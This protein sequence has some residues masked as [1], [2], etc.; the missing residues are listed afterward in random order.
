[1]QNRK[2]VL[3]AHS[4]AGLFVN[5]VKVKFLCTVNVKDGNVVSLIY[6]EKGPSFTFHTDLS[7]RSSNAVCDGVNG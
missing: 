6:V 2:I 4:V 5:G 1:M 7:N 3:S